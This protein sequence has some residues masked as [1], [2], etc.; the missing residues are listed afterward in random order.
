MADTEVY[1]G[2]GLYARHDGW[3]VGLR[4]P[5]E[6]GDHWVALE[7]PVL[8]KF[9]QFI[10]LD[11]QQAMEITGRWM[12]R[13]GEDYNAAEARGEPLRSVGEYQRDGAGGASATPSGGGGVE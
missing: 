2:D 9:L 8:S 12:T 11:K 4:A 7:P 10:G 5:R 1:L 6:G 13:M 3:H